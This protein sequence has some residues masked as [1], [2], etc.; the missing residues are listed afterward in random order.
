MAI[1]EMSGMSNDFVFNTLKK[2]IELL[3]DIDIKPMICSMKFI[4]IT[5]GFISGLGLMTIIS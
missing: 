1:K 3:K 5:T 4:S 2:D